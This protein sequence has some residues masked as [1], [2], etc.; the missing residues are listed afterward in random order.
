MEF[1]EWMRA[2]MEKRGWSQSELARRM[3][4][5]PGTV[6]NVVNGNRQAGPDFCIALAQVLRM[7]REE[8]FRARGWL[9]RDPQAVVT[10]EVDPR[11]IQMTATLQ[12]LPCDVREKVLKVWEA[13]LDL[14]G[15]E[16]PT[17]KTVPLRGRN[18]L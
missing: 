16:D 6:G 11:L 1:T 4:S 15:V 18:G 17:K 5:D 10:P 7:S 2:E 3:Q 13:A 8:V 9:V 12:E 14:A